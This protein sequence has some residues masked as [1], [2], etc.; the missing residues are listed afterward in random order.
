[1]DKTNLEWTRSAWPFSPRVLASSSTPT[2]RRVFPRDNSARVTLTHLKG[3]RWAREEDPQAFVGEDL[4]VRGAFWGGVS[5]LQES[6]FLGPIHLTQHVEATKSTKPRGRQ[7]TPVS[8]RTGLM[9]CRYGLLPT[10]PPH[11]EHSNDAVCCCSKL[12]LVLN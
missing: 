2:W 7:T 6:G 9:A 8:G 5:L 1:M 10:L 4:P 11:V 3:L 12:K